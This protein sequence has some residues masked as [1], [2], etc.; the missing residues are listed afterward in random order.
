M[1]LLKPFELL[2]RIVPFS[3]LSSYLSNVRKVWNNVF[4]NEKLQFKHYGYHDAKGLL[5]DMAVVE[6][7]GK[8]QKY[9]LKVGKGKCQVRAD[10][11][12]NMVLPFL[13]DGI[14]LSTGPC[15]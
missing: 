4:P 12:P 5:A 2:L 11:L 1:K 7:V 8:S 10:H 15:A 9:V 14:F 3:Q 13:H 6:Q